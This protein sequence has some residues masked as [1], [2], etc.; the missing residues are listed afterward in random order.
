MT[1]TLRFDIGNDAREAIRATL[2]LVDRNRLG[3]N[4]EATSHCRLLVRL[5]EKQMTRWAGA[6][7]QGHN[8][9]SLTVKLPAQFRDAYLLYDL[10]TRLSA[11]IP[12]LRTSSGCLTLSKKLRV[13]LG[14]PWPVQAT[15]VEDAFLLAIHEQPGDLANWMAYGDF[16]MEGCAGSHGIQRGTLIAGL[17]G[18]KPVKIRYGVPELAEKYT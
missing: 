15:A 2:Y 1:A 16:L 18:P 13:S 4:D 6:Y 14:L 8:V 17:L 3:D 12:D 10:A 7:R 9:W 11:Q 5:G